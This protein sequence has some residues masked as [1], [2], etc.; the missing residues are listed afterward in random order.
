MN[1]YGYNETLGREL[2]TWRERLADVTGKIDVLPSIEK[3]RLTPYIEGLHILLTEMDERIDQLCDDTL[4]SWPSRVMV[5]PP[6]VKREACDFNECEGV[7]YDYEF[8]G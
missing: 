4:T 3:Y 6:V 1:T 8:G 7:R 5:H 2:C